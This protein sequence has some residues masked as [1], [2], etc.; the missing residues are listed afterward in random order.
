MSPGCRLAVL[1]ATGSVGR[2]A[3]QVAAAFPEIFQ[4]VALA[5]SSD[6]QGL[7]KLAARFRPELLVLA[8]GTAAGKLSP[9]V[10]SACRVEAGAEALERLAAAG[11]YDCLL[12][13]TVGQAGLTAVCSALQAGKRVALANKEVLVM[14]GELVTGLAARHGGEIIPVDSEHAAAHQLLDGLDP[15]AVRRLILTA[16]GGP[17]LGRDPASMQQVSVAEAL[18]H[19]RWKMGPKISIDS[20]TLMNKGFEIIE[21]R[22]LFSL[23]ADNIQV[24]V[25]PQSMVH[26]LVETMD[27]GLLAQLAEPDMRLP[28]AYALAYPRRLPLPERLPDIVSSDPCRV[29]LSFQPAREEDFPALRLC[30]QALGRGG[31]VAAALSVADEVVVQAFLQEH[32]PFPAIL[33]ILQQVLD[34]T[35]ELPASNLEQYLAAGQ[36]GADLARKIIARRFGP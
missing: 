20:A 9:L 25:H 8:D 3:L 28:I 19:P 18:S 35:G 1:G 24:L 27:G 30:R 32:I 7:A 12:A 17:F 6:F 2:Q 13:A 15:A 4:V 26:A 11:D 10:D 5:A 14:A 16:S 23:P 33:E 34:D 36:R 22:W 29:E 21:A 31:G